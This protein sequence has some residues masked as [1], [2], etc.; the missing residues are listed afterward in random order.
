MR[1]RSS[2][3]GKGCFRWLIAGVILIIMFGA[4]GLTLSARPDI[5][6]SA[7][8]SL[9]KV[10]GDE[11][12]ANL[13][14]VLFQ[15]Q[16]F[17]QRMKYSSGIAAP[18]APWQNQA[19]APAAEIATPS[20]M[21][22]SPTSDLGGPGSGGKDP[23]ATPPT[24][25]EGTNT[26]AA[27][28]Q[29]T[30]DGLSPTATSVPAQTE[31]P[32]P[33]AWQMAALKPM[34]SLSGEGIWEPYIRDAAGRIVAYRTFLQPDPKRPYAMA[35]VIAFDLKHTRLHF[36]IGFEEP[37]A[38]GVAKRPGKMPE[39]DKAPGLLLAM[40]NGGFK[41]NHGQFGAMEDGFISM[42]PRD[43][44]ATLVMYTD[45]RVQMG[46]WGSSIQPSPDM[47]AWRQNGPLVIADGKIN[48]RIYNNVIRDWGFTVTGGSPTWRSGIGTSAD[49]ETL[50]YF[51]GSGLTIENLAKVMA[52]AGI[53]QGMQLDINNYWVHFIAVR[54]DPNGQRLLEPLF[55]DMM[56][57]NIGR[58]LDAYSRDFF[59]I[60]AADS[61]GK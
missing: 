33:S 53:A 31:V 21:P 37:Y 19:Q 12:V 35:A 17:V 2:R 56:K 22:S 44:L 29:N 38:V 40:F 30:P 16:D 59:Y 18:A 34:G 8:D 60:T 39:A 11:V 27:I 42:P 10:F 41:A 23:A 6:A 14:M 45:G 7:A 58:Y 5:A 3:A 24:P 55:P 47:E 25:Q 15:A 26:A 46:V 52:S 32:T 20:L 28:A 51:A 36:V 4:A 48:S 50:Y 49:N 61:T 9:R 43:G 54:D 57:E 13:E 1:I